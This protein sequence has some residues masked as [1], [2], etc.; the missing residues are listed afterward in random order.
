[1]SS[2]LRTDLI[3][4]HC[5]ACDAV[6]KTSLRAIDAKFVDLLPVYVCANCDNRAIPRRLWLLT[7]I[8]WGVLFPELAF[9]FLLLGAALKIG[10]GTILFAGFGL[11][12]AAA[13][14]FQYFVLQRLLDW[15]PLPVVSDAVPGATE[16]VPLDGEPLRILETERLVLRELAV[17]D[18]RFILEL[19]N[20]PSWIRFI[21]D[22]GVRTLDDARGYIV[23][24]PMAMYERNGFGLWLTEL[25]Q[26]GTPIGLCG[27]I[28]RD[29]LDDVDIGFAFLPQ[30][31]ANGYAF[32]S[33]SAVLKY[34][35]DELGL[36]RVVA[37]TSPD[38]FDSIK[39]IEKLGLKFERTLN[40]SGDSDE[41]SLF[42]IDTGQLVS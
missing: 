31:R 14:T 35:I 11:S 21:G 5:P 24:G 2:K 4:F 34:G 37:I 15:Q 41:V 22:K 39:L 33:A 6:A 26:G 1:M 3:P 13:G 36:V 27:L 32:E 10:V 42:A 18:D 40:L 7:F 12:A 16:V 9:L 29:S 20:D 19:L 17:A 8:A 30:F 28:K 25:K 38:N 23:N